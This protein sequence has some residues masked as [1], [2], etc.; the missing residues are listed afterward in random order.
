VIE[1]FLCSG[2]RHSVFNLV[3]RILHNT[4]NTTYPMF[5]GSAENAFNP[6]LD[7]Q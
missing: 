2:T 7:M 3:A 1:K 5:G 6:D 4:A